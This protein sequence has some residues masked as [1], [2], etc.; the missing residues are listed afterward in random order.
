M[1]S[2]ICL[3]FLHLSFSQR[4]LDN[5]AA[6]RNALLS[7]KGATQEELTRLAEAYTH[8]LGHQNQKQKIKH[9]VK[10]KEENFDLK[11]VCL[12]GYISEHSSGGEK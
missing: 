5:F 7:E 2:Q 3:F 4:Q 8:L 11:Q 6:E 9:V 1:L 12:P 10:L